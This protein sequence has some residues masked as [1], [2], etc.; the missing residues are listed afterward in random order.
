MT[1][2]KKSMIFFI[3]VSLFL[4]GNS[5][6]V[7]AITGSMGNARMILYPEFNGKFYEPI[8]KT[9]L[10]KN[11]NN[12]S[13]NVTLELDESGKEFI[14]LIDKSIILQPNE[15]TKARFTVK[16]KN[17]GK[18]EG[19]INVFFTSAESKEPGVALSS[20]IIAIARENLNNNSSATDNENEI[21]GEGKINKGVIFLI[22][23]T[24]V[25]LAVLVFLLSMM[26]KRR[27]NRGRKNE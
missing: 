4:I 6:A 16:V 26:K 3:L 22:I 15:E 1:R 10:I 20:T 18:Y 2:G 21:K 25:L 19:R 24:L 17:E 23:S 12:V 14:E 7:N 11:V 13:I 27:K 5:F 9:I 8:D